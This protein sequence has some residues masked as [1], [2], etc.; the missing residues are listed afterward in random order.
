LIRDAKFEENAT[1]FQCNC[2]NYFLETAVAVNPST[3]LTSLAPHVIK[4]VGLGTEVHPHHVVI[5]TT[6][7]VIASMP[8][9]LTD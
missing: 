5:L 9:P 1:V 6:T 2:G 7:K 4:L 3:G 8:L